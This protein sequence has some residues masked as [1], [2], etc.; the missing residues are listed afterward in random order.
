MARVP[1]VEVQGPPGRII[2]NISDLPGY[3]KRGYTEVG[4][5]R[6]IKPG[7]EP[8][9]LPPG[10]KEDE[11]AEL[12]RVMDENAAARPSS[13]FYIKATRADNQYLALGEEGKGTWVSGRKSATVWSSLAEPR[14][15]IVDNGLTDCDVETVEPPQAKEKEKATPAG[16]SVD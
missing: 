8:I 4:G 14:K 15:F 9:D 16:N 6:K 7:D 12:I 5:T 10:M 2:I 1:V 11:S 3:L 13:S